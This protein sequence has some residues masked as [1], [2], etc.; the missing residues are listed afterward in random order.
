MRL[1]GHRLLH[2]VLLLALERAD[3]EAME[4]VFLY[5]FNGSNHT[6]TFDASSCDSCS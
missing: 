2:R 1:L 6:S 3:P 4:Q 5:V